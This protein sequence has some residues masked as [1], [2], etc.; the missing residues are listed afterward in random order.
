MSLLRPTFVRINL[1]QIMSNFRRL[2]SLNPGQPFLCPMV[3]ANAYGLGD[4][5][6]AKALEK[7]RC[8]SMGVASVEEGMRLRDHHISANILVFGFQ[9]K[10][11]CDQILRE[12]LTPVVSNFQQ[13]EDLVGAAKEYLDIHIKFNTGMNRLG[14]SAKDI[15][16]ILNGLFQ[17]PNIHVAGICSHL[18]DGA[19]I[20]EESSSTQKQIAEFEKIKELF[21]DSEIVYHLYNSA[22]MASLYRNKKSF[23][24]GSRPGLLIYGIDPEPEKSVRP[25]IGPVVQFQSQVIEVH[26]VAADAVVSYGGTWQAPRDSIIGIVAAGYADGVCRSLSNVGHLLVCGRKVPIR[27]V[28]C[29]DY[30]M[31]DLTDIGKA[32]QDFIGEEAV[33]IGIQGEEEISVEEV[34]EKS[35]RITYEVM[36]GI[37]ERVPRLYGE[38]YI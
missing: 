32:P 9:G 5:A 27:G 2:Q 1:D 36:T 16:N 13:L 18:Y 26:E 17:N 11:A 7:E 6:I 31:V 30:V 19:N 20:C 34:A 28:V 24:Y 12:C 33:I 23:A 29:M 8:N 38:V 22:A 4:V 37:G 3:K 10:E 15:P 35:G 14:F 25:L 21:S